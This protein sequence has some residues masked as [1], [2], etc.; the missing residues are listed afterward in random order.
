MAFDP[1]LELND[2]LT[3]LVAEEFTDY[4]V[5]F[6]GCSIGLKC[7]LHSA[8]YALLEESEYLSWSVRH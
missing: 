4:L 6:S 5:N 7:P 1:P 2:L 3:E 8:S